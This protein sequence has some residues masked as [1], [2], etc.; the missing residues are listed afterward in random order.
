MRFSALL[1]AF[2]VPKY[3]NL[4]NV[5]INYAIYRPKYA[6]FGRK[7]QFT[8]PKMHFVA[9]FV[10]SLQ[11]KTNH[12]TPMRKILF[13]L[14]ALFASMAT[15]A[16]EPARP[17]TYAEVIQAEGKTKA[18]IFSSLRE[19]VVTTYVNGK[20]VTQLEDET[21]GTI[22]LKAAT[23]YHKGGMYSAY[24][25]YLNYTLKLQ[26]KDGR[27]RVEMS[28]INH[29]NLP[30]RA[31]DCSLGTL[32][33]AEKSGKGG[34]NKSAHNKIWR[35]LKTASRDDFNELVASLKNLRYVE[36]VEEDW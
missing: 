4:R 10:V 19:W 22:I 33:T 1:S 35:E 31:Q 5:A 36:A 30:G 26:A 7:P 27:F 20:A 15:T 6:V 29:E 16:Q 24:E 13:V 25:G 9:A 21:T 32:T 23:P 34:L 8:P 11:S 18:E 2:S 14:V 12:F 17:L 28:N 3:R